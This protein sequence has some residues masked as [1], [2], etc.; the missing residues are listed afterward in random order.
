MT[1]RSCTEMARLIAT[2]DV[3]IGSRY[4]KGGSLDD[5]WPALAE[6]AFR[7]RELLCADDPAFSIARHD[8][9]LSH[10]AA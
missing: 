9:R 3:V 5:N 1:P 2:N 10:V 7:L 6:G 4:V 8:D